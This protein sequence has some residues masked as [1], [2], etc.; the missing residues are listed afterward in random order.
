VLLKAVTNTMAK[1]GATAKR[2]S[3]SAARASSATGG[4][5][6][7]ARRQ[8]DFDLYDDAD[9]AA[10]DKMVYEHQMCESPPHIINH[11]FL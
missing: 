3:V 2:S 8:A 11:P 6:G 9:D 5:A 10:L 7:A 4:H 1:C